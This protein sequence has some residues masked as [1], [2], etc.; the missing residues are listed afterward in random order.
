MLDD[1]IN[2]EEMATATGPVKIPIGYEPLGVLGLQ[3]VFEA[4][5]FKQNLLCHKNSC[6]I[7]S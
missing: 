4:H 5:E 1:E 3:K 2:D 6:F 7:C